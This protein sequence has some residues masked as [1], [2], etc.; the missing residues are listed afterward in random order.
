MTA[1]KQALARRWD[2]PTVR[3][4]EDLLDARELASEG[5][6]KF[7]G[8]TDDGL[9]DLRAVPISR[10]HDQPSLHQIDMSYCTWDGPTCTRIVATDCRF[11]SM[12]ID[13]V[14]GSH[15]TRCD[16]GESSIVDGLG[17]PGTTFH[18]CDFSGCRFSSG[19]FLSCE[20]RECQ[21]VSSHLPTVDFEEC[22][23]DGCD[24]SGAV[25]KSGSFGGSTFLNL[26]NS[27]RYVNQ[28]DMSRCQYD[29]APAATIVDLADTCMIGVRL[30][31]RPPI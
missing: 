28:H 13:G 12:R 5:L 22:L 16:F 8:R 21:F 15:F 6:G 24:F 19:S 11:R 29:P 18:G 9:V 2:K 17:M 10:N 7:A 26:K 3:L 1:I 31:D 30:G 20:F 23:F 4:I 25:F 27:I 14:L